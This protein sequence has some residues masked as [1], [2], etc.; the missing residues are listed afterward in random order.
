MCKY[1]YE[2]IKKGQVSSNLKHEIN[3]V[4]FLLLFDIEFKR[5]HMKF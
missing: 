3:P 2:D 5:L 4:L 1:N